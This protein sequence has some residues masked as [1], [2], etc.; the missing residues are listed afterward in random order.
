MTAS[1]GWVR[2]L[3]AQLMR[4]RRNVILA[5]LAAIFG[6]ASQILVP[7]IARQIVDHVVVTRRDPLWPWLLVLFATALLAFG[8]AYVRRYRGGM[9]A[10]AVQL[11]LR[12]AMHDRLQ[13]M[14]LGDARD[15]ADRPT[16]VA[17]RTPTRRWSRAC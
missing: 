16:R 4:H 3:W 11:D 10:L 7:L 8:L 15:D 17:R 1:P 5:F 12:N 6:S 14:D 2:R 9:A 13:R